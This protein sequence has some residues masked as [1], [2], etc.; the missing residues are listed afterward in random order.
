[1]FGVD[2]EFHIIFFGGFAREN[3]VKTFETTNS[4]SIDRDGFDTWKNMSKEVKVLEIS[5]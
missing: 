5:N 2:E 4:I 3:F 1:M